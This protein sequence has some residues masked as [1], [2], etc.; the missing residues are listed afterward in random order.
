MSTAGFANAQGDLFLCRNPQNGSEQCKRLNTAEDEN[1]ILCGGCE[2]WIHNKCSV[3]EKKVIDVVSHHNLSY[4]CAYCMQRKNALKV[5]DYHKDFDTILKEFQN[6]KQELIQEF[7][8][9]KQ[10][11]TQE[12]QETKRELQE[13]KQKVNDMATRAELSTTSVTDMKQQIDNIKFDEVKTI[14][15]DELYKTREKIDEANNNVQLNSTAQEVM[16]TQVA[17][18]LD[19]NNLIVDTM[20]ARAADIVHQPAEA[21]AWT[22]VLSKNAKRK[23]ARYESNTLIIKAKE[24]QIS[25][26]SH[27]EELCKVV[28][29]NL[30]DVKIDKMRFTPNKCVILNLP[31]PESI[32]KAK[33]ALQDNDKVT[34]NNTKKAQPKIMIPYVPLMEI[35]DSEEDKAEFIN[36]ILY[37]NANLKNFTTQ[38]IEIINIRSSK[39]EKHKHVIVKCSPQIRK[40]IYQ[41]NNEIYTMYGHYEIHDN[42]YVKICNHCQGYGHI[43]QDCKNK[44]ISKRPPTCGKC[45]ENH[46]TIECTKERKDFKCSQCTKKNLNNDR[47]HAVKDHKCQAYMEQIRRIAQN[48]EHGY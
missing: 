14:L 12:L 26:E 21:G 11:L 35:G 37:K 1:A 25:D 6:T 17:S 40:A 29:S 10:E 39:L 42:Y 44:Q 20:N 41:N 2:R 23:M 9:T 7:Q 18:V 45:A 31:D 24:G 43:E 34:A 32:E 16:A 3:L 8:N 19:Q 13:M 28:K 22:E 27:E 47:N 33:N 30:K 38:D 36:S 46:K 15:Q 5:R 48:T 4:T